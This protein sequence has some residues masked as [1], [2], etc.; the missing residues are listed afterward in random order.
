M[1]LLH[2]ARCYV[3]SWKPS[4]KG[5]I[6]MNMMGWRNRVGFLGG[7]E[8][9]EWMRYRG[10]WQGQ[11]SYLYKFLVPS[12]TIVSFRLVWHVDIL[13]SI[14]PRKYYF[15]K[16]WKIFHLSSGNCHLRIGADTLTQDNYS[17]MHLPIFLI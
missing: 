13:Y 6:F 2:G 10:V 12:W 3:T 17:A 15:F 11:K 5:F 8:Q 14:H 16:K 9:I 7:S 1:L 4:K